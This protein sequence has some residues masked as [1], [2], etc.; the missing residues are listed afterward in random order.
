MRSPE[1]TLL[2]DTVTILVSVNIL[3][4]VCCMETKLVPDSFLIQPCMVVTAPFS[5]LPNA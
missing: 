3:C 2:R 1:T 4:A 5:D